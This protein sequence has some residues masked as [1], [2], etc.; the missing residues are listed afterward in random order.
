VTDRE[1]DERL[2]AAFQA[3]DRTAAGKCSDEELERIWR[4]VSGTLPAAERRE[5]VDRIAENPASAEAWQIAQQF[6]HTSG[7]EAAI[8]IEDRRRSRL[9]LKQPAWLA[10]AAALFVVI[11]VGLSRWSTEDTFR[12][13]DQQIV[14]S[15]VPSDAT[16]PRDAFRLSWTPATQGSRYE[17]RM[18]TE[19]LRVL[20]IVADLTESELLVE[21]SALS[22][23]AAGGRVLWQVVATLPGGER[24]TSQTFV[25]RVR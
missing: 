13:P 4:A 20:S 2:R 5:V 17:V 22:S 7:G 9:L 19:D 25:A 23:V 6:W 16:L 10:A 21:P 1:S 24:T 14:E 12:D 3:F 15:L 11:G 18:T 8:E